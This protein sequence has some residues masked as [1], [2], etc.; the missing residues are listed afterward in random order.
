VAW[1]ILEQR[2]TGNRMIGWGA[3]FQV[4]GLGHRDPGAGDQVQVA[5]NLPFVLDS[6]LPPLRV[7]GGSPRWQVAGVPPSVIDSVICHLSSTLSSIH[8]GWQV[9]APGGRWRVF[10]P[11][12]SIQSSVIDPVIDSFRVA[13]GSPGWQVAGFYIQPSTQSSTQSS[14][15]SSVINSVI[16]HRPSHPPLQVA[17]APPC[18]IDSVICHPSSIQSS[19][20]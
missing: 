8:F 13:G 18:L 19:T 2:E 10:R 6:V 15:Q 1:E 3:H 14:M 7:A 4:S 11:L 20:Q 5:G 12:S 17:G 9:A 16:C